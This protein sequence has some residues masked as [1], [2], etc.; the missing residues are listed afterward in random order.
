MD[1]DL[2][3]EKKKKRIAWVSYIV[4]ILCLIGMFCFSA[5]TGSL[6]VS[7]PELL[8]GLFLEYNEDVYIFIINK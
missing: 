6:K 7:F 1:Y 5:D 2:Q 8:K 4:V 3:R